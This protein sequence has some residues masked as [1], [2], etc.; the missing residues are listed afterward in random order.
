MATPGLTEIEYAPAG[1][2]TDDTVGCDINSIRINNNLAL[3][4]GGL[5]IGESPQQR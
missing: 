2:H 1:R 3:K 4:P 5:E